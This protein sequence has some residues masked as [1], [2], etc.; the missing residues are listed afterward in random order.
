MIKTTVICDLCGNKAE[1]DVLYLLPRVYIDIPHPC[2]SRKMEK[3]HISV[4]NINLCNECARKIS[5]AAFGND[6]RRI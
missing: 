6:L 1:S 4:S 5:R 3:E 2:N